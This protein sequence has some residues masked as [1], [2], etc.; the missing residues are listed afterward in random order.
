MVGWLVGG[1]VA[2]L[3]AGLVVGQSV[4]GQWVSDSVSQSAFDYDKR[5]LTS[6]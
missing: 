6:Y 5:N 2:E 1:L 4:S 3:F